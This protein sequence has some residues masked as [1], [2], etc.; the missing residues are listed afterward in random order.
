MPT[1]EFIIP[2]YTRVNHLMCI[3]SSIAAQTSSNWK[4]HVISDA[5][6]DGILNKIIDFW[7][8]DERIKFTILDKRS[9]D[10]GHTPRNFGLNESKQEW[11]VM[12]GEDNYYA[13]I[14]V[15]E[16]LKEVDDKTNFIFCNM[17]TNYNNQQY[18]PMQCKI[19]L[20]FIDIGCFMVR[21]E[22]A[23]QIGIEVKYKEIADGVL[24]DKYVK[25]FGGKIKQILKVLYVHN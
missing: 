16:F 25:K 15:E 14:F 6:P 19:E 12:S 23:K 13:P 8:Y 10:W 17:V 7:N 4:I 3:I 2:T 9:N 11:V 5:S 21:P 24:A 22:L 18:I 1:I 20:G